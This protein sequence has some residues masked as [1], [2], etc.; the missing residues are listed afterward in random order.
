MSSA[1]SAPV[2]VSVRARPCVCFRLL[3]MSQVTAHCG[4]LCRLPAGLWDSDWD[5]DW[6]WDW[7]W[8]RAGDGDWD[9][10]FRAAFRWLPLLTMATEMAMAMAMATHTSTSNHNKGPK[11]S[12]PRDCVFVCGCVG[13]SYFTLQTTRERAKHRKQ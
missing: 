8:D 11:R 13:K 5:W 9:W 7:D 6:N 12:F 10:G 3:A 1:P 2:A 4:R